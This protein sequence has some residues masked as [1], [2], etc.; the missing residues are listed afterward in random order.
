MSQ[1]ADNS[2]YLYMAACCENHIQNHV[3]FQLQTASFCRV[4]GARF[5]KDDNG[6]VCR[7]LVVLFLWSLGNRGALIGKAASLHRSALLAAPLRG[8]CGTASE[9]CAGHGSADSFIAARSIAISRAVR[10]GVQS[11]GI[12]DQMS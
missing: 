7:A 1:T 11:L 2:I 6:S 3:T 5:L 9:T 8:H 10:Q 12:H 4:I